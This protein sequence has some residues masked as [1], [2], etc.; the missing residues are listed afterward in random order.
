MKVVLDKE[1]ERFEYRK[2]A[3]L[4]VIEG[5]SKHESVEVQVKENYKG[6]D[7]HLSWGYKGGANNL[8]IEVGFIN[9]YSAKTY[10]E[11]RTRFI[12]TIWRGDCNHGEWVFGNKPEDRAIKY[13][14]QLEPWKTK[15]DK[16]VIFYQCSG[17]KAV[18]AADNGYPSFM[19]R[20]TEKTKKHFSE[21]L[22]RPHPQQPERAG[23]R[24][25]HKGS[26]N[27]A[28]EWADVGISFSSTAAI[29]CI[30]AGV[31]A[32]T[33]GNFSMAWSITSHE[34][35]KVVRPPR[36]QWLNNLMYAQWTHAELASGEFWEHVRE[37]YN[38]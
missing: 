19:R 17:D 22:I 25:I 20:L 16:A 30:L 11:S 27:D 4:S 35:D 9:D 5:I 37:G 29:D 10:A 34:L 2:V 32:I 26:L 3:A 13:D 31:P 28:L 1:L 14:I 36:Q 8:V 15:Q 23:R 18:L 6:P 7:L 24:N 38:P 21:V 33:F 12:S